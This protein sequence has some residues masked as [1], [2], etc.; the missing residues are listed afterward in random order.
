MNACRDRLRA[1]RRVAVRTV[2][3]DDAREQRDGWAA[4]QARVAGDPG[5]D[6]ARRDL[7]ARASRAW[8]VF[9]D[10]PNV[11]GAGAASVVLLVA[12]IGDRWFVW[13]AH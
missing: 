12:P 8:L 5:E 6:L 2:P 11:R 10:H 7:L 13:I 9:V 4:T 1:R 3:A